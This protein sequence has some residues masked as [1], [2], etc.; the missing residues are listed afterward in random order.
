MPHSSNDQAEGSLPHRAAPWISVL[1]GLV[2]VAA[3]VAYWVSSRPVIPAPTNSPAATTSSSGGRTHDGSASRR[4][5]SGATFVEPDTPPETTLVDR[6]PAEVPEDDPQGDGWSTEVF[7]NAVKGQLKHLGELL[8][9]PQDL[10]DASH[11]SE[12]I[13]EDAVIEVLRPAQLDEVFR[14]ATLVVQR[15]ASEQQPSNDA[16]TELSHAAAAE[17][18]AHFVAAE[19][20]SRSRVEFKVFRV[21]FDPRRETMA[22]VQWIARSETQSVQRNATWR[23]EWSDETPPRITAIELVDYEEVTSHDQNGTWF[24]DVTQAVIG[25]NESFQQQLARGE[26]FWNARIQG[27]VHSTFLGIHGGLAIADVNGDGLDDVYVCQP[28]GLP[29]R[30]YVQNPDGT[31]TDQSAAAGVDWLEYTSS[32]LLVDLDND[33]DRDLAMLGLHGLVLMSN[34]GAGR[35]EPRAYITAPMKATAL[36]AADYDVDSDLDLYVVC[37]GP[38]EASRDNDTFRRPSDFMSPV[39]YDDANNGAANMLL[40]NEGDFQFADATEQSGLADNNSRWSFAAAWEDYDNDNDLDL[41]VANDFGRNN[42]YRNDAGHFHDVAAEAGVEDI[43]SGMSVSWG[44]Y[45]GDGWM[46]LYVG[47]MFSAAGGRITYQRRFK[48]GASDGRVEQFRRMARGNSLF[49]NQQ[50]GTFRDVSEEAAVTM[51][52]WAWSSRFADLNNDG[53]LDLLVANGFITNED[54]HDL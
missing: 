25:Q 16:S 21:A 30:L 15:F 22:Y 41:Y 23:S 4:T 46:D 1:I 39:P 3:A 47:N 34:S 24:A 42:L 14:D 8:A 27:S 48:K 38:G 12:M 9:R 26:P 51:G 7:H 17:R 31:V 53:R 40:S 45:N 36:A 28:G 49:E 18:L 5:W 54:L 37:Y 50:D 32:A 19:D 2:V 10:G 43:A 52:R 33:G 20:S 44:D 13:A 29:N 6:S 11:L 35:F